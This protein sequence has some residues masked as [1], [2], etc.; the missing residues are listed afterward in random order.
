MVTLKPIKFQSKDFDLLFFIFTS[1]LGDI[2][3]FSEFVI[4]KSINTNN[5][6]L[7]K[8]YLRGLIPLK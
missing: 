7:I 8:S 5:R 2:K 1:I 4:V 3:R 6:E